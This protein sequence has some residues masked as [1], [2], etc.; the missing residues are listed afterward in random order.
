MAAEARRIVRCT[1]VKGVRNAA[2]ERLCCATRTIGSPPPGCAWGSVCTGSGGSTV[3]LSCAL[4]VDPACLT[5][6][7][8][9]SAAAAALNLRLQAVQSVADAL[10]T[11][12]E[13]EPS[14]TGCQTVQ[15]VPERLDRLELLMS[16]A[17]AATCS[18][19]CRPGR[20]PPP[21]PHEATSGASS[22]TRVPSNS[23]VALLNTPPPPLP[24]RCCCLGRVLTML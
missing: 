8:D 10:G 14:A 23:L 11:Q 13:P 1:W 12:A 16:A 20:S 3:S 19:D 9:T 6:K 4:P 7:T 21:P 2:Q 17:A 15:R 5:K 24:A 18:R 22:S